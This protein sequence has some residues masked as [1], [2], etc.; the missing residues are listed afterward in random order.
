MTNVLFTNLIKEQPG[1]WQKSRQL[2][3]TVAA[4][5]FKKKV[6]DGQKTILKTVKEAEIVS[7]GCFHK[8]FWL[9]HGS[10]LKVNCFPWS[11]LARLPSMVT[12]KPISLLLS[13]QMTAFEDFVAI[14]ARFTLHIQPAPQQQEAHGRPCVIFL[15]S[16]KC[17]ET[18]SAT[19]RDTSTVSGLVCHLLAQSCTI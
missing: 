12:P 4:P 5:P 2:S 17:S 18:S 3:I 9:L 15:L 16:E 10:W 7:F 14:Q 19:S 11:S 13:T 8:T 1:L 6:L